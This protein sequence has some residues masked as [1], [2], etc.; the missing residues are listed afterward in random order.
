MEA[1]LS[2]LSGCKSLLCEKTFRN[3]GDEGS[4][5]GGTT[6]ILCPDNLLHQIRATK[7][8]DGFH[9][10]GHPIFLGGEQILVD[11]L[12]KIVHEVGVI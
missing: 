8:L 5:Y 2:D 7:M 4:V 12:Q 11:F 6:E 9:L 3:W 10:A 1:P